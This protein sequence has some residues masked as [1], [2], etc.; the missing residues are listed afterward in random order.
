MIF[1]VDKL[2]KILLKKLTSGKQISS[3]TNPFR[4]SRVMR[5][6]L[7][8]R[9]RLRV[10]APSV[11]YGQQVRKRPTDSRGVRPTEGDCHASQFTLR[12]RGK[13]KRYCE[14]VMRIKW[15]Q[16]INVMRCKQCDSRW[17]FIRLD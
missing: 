15:V 3:F 10:R 2:S 5:N 8:P 17:V 13:R 16:I 7:Q 9:R 11:Y 12:I 1:E 6:D 4:W 14:D